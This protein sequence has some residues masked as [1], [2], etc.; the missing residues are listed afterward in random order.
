[1]HNSPD[2]VWIMFITDQESRD[3]LINYSS[4]SQWEVDPNTAA[5]LI[6]A[7]AAVRLPSPPTAAS[8]DG[9]VGRQ[10]RPTF[11]RRFRRAVDRRRG[12]AAG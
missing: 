10:I 6:L 11:I 9:I 4:G 1:M 5:A 8:F 2:P 3:K 12:C 7:G